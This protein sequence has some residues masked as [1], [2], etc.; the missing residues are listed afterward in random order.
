MKQLLLIVW[1]SMTAA[2]HPAEYDVIIRNG[3]VYDGTGK[4][5]VQT[6]VAIR[7]DRIVELGR[8][9]PGTGNLEIDAAGLA[10][11]PGFINM[12]S[13]ADE[14]LFQDGRS[15]GDIRQGVTL[16][17]LGEGESMGPLTPAMRKDKVDSQGDIKFDVTW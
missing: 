10:V 7:R 14:S 15:Q 1:I 3:T 13:W 6:D 12:L 5:P 16:E 4:S 17:V 8:F 2:A 9:A 11:A